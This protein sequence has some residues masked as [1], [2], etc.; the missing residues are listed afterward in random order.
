ML[1]HHRM[2]AIRHPDGAVDDVLLQQTSNGIGRGPDKRLAHDLAERL[3]KFKGMRPVWWRSSEI[4]PFARH[5]LDY[6]TRKERLPVRPDLQQDADELGGRRRL[7]IFG[8]LRMRQCGAVERMAVQR[9]GMLDWPADQ[10]P[11]GLETS[12]GSDLRRTAAHASNEDRIA[13]L[14]DLKPVRTST[15]QRVRVCKWACFGIRSPGIQCDGEGPAAHVALGLNAI[16][17]EDL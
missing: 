6:V 16:P 4:I 15:S 17:G 8:L 1:P 5:L 14:D 13:R 12:F 7:G 9:G 10:L 11:P 3:V 2:G